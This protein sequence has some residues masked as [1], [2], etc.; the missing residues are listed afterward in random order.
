[1]E[2]SLR[3]LA[4]LGVKNIHFEK[5]SLAG[6]ASKLIK[7][8]TPKVFVKNFK[9]AMKLSHKLGVNLMNSSLSNLFSPRTFY[10]NHIAGQALMIGPR[11]ILTNCYE[12]LD[13]I[14]SPFYFGALENSEIA[15]LKMGKIAEKYSVEKI[16]PCKKCFAKIICGAGCPQQNWLKH[17]NLFKP[18]KENCWITKELIKEAIIQLFENA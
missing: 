6:R 14:D 1:M 10:C 9:K 2:E 11:G 17:K 16:K 8:P 12:H 4:G 15:L 18:V 3:L 7:E 13:D 5:V